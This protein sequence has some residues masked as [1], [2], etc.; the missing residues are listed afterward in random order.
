MAAAMTP[1]E[2]VSL[3]LLPEQVAFVVSRARAIEAAPSQI[4]ESMSWKDLRRIESAGYSSSVIRGCLVLAALASG[5]PRGLLEIA[6]ELEG[7]PQS[8]YRYL[9]TL[10]RVG[11][12]ERAERRRY[13][14]A[15]V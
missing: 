3:V 12:V 10:E 9:H 4:V 15:G 1:E 6:S 2:G 7:R 11:L 5:R 14:L 13:R 8:V